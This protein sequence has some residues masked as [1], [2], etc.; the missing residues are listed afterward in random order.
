[1][2]AIFLHSLQHIR[3]PT[4][5]SL[6]DDVVRSRPHEVHIDAHLLQMVAKGREGPLKTNIVLLFVLILHKLVIL[7][8]Y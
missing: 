8:I 5:E 6:E 4:G 7:F 3:V 2:H 1:M